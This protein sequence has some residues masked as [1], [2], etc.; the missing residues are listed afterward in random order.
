MRKK[1]TLNNDSGL[2]TPNPYFDKPL[3]PTIEE[4]E[5]EE[6][7]TVTPVKKTSISKDDNVLELLLNLR[8]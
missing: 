6:V 3:M 4:V 1:S 7:K 5:V 8:R 2:T